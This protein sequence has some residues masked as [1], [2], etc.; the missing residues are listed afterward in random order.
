MESFYEEGHSGMQRSILESIAEHSGEEE[1][2]SFRKKKNSIKV[3][4]EPLPNKSLITSVKDL[5]AS[6]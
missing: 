3:R 4:E 2:S 5:R 6:N 1:M